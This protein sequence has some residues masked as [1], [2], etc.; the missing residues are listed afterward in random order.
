MVTFIKKLVRAT[1]FE[2]RRK[3]AIKKAQKDANLLRRRFLVL[4][5][6]GKPVVVSM[7]GVKK[8]IRC[9]RFAKG[10]TAE[11]AREIALYVA[12]PQPIKK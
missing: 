6:N 5:Q 1:V 12:D 7:Q 11:K 10:F 8:L 3:R 4:V 9:H 2:W